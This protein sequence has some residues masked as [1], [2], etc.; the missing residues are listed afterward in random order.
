MKL[1]K[2]E[3][4]NEKI[5]VYILGIKFTKNLKNKNKQTKYENNACCI[6]IDIEEL[7]NKN[8]IFP[9]PTGIVIGSKVKLGNNIKIWQNVTIGAKSDI[10]WQNQKYPEIG[11]NVLIYANSVIIGDV[12]IG[13]N[14]IIGA[15]SLVTCDVE[16]NSI[17]AG[18]PAKKIGINK[19]KNKI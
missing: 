9:H 17:Y 19:I 12:K 16:A 1:F 3:K 18:I 4:S 15:M 14:S 6:G 5:I 13:S 8:I 2:I 10:D 11:D 7:K